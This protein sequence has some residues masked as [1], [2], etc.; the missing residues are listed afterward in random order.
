M[1]KC[2]GITRRITG[3]HMAMSCS[4]QIQP[5]GWTSYVRNPLGDIGLGD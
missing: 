2:K 3:G 1:K 4:A 5:Y